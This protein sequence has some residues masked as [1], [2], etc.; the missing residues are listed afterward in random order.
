MATKLSCPVPPM[1]PFASRKPTINLYILT[2]QKR[3]VLW[4]AHFVVE[5]RG[6]PHLALGPGRRGPRAQR[7][8]LDELDVARGPVTRALG[9]L[10]VHRA[11]VAR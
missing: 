7:E 11:M 3:S 6:D 4:I 5:P 10:D 2:K 8:L 1:P 9:D